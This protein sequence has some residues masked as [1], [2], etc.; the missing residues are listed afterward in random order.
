MRRENAVATPDRW[1]GRISNE[2]ATGAK[3]PPART[4]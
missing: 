4:R 3:P 2:A 1:S